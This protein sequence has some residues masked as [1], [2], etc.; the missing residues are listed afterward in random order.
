MV[1]SSFAIS[2]FIAGRHFATKDG[3]RE[4]LDQLTTDDEATE[5]IKQSSV[6]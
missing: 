4:L 6:S 1:I 3:F 2:Y 5:R